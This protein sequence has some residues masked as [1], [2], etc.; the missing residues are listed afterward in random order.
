MAQRPLRPSRPVLQLLSSHTQVDKKQRQG[1]R[2]K[3]TFDT[4]KTPV[5]RLI[6]SG[7]LSPVQIQWLREFQ[8]SQDPLALHRQ[9]EVLLSHPETSANVTPKPVMAT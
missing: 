9:L 4:A 3:K 1:S 6:E 2:V 7:T 8:A 5:E